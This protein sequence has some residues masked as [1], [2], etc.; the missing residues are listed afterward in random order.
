MENFLKHPALIVGI[1]AVITVFFGIQLPRVELDNNNIRFLP[2]KNQAKI[3]SDYIDNTFGGQVMILVGIE[4]PYRSVFEKGFLGRV[5]EFV[6]AV[7]GVEFVKTINSIMSTQYISGD[8]ESIIVSDL[9]P[10]DFSGTAEEIAELRRRIASW[11]LLQGALVSNDLSATQIVITLDVMTADSARPEVTRSLNAIKKLAGEIFTDEEELYFTG[12]PILSATVNESII[13]DNLLLIP[14]VVLVVLALLFFSFRRL[15]FVVLPIL[16]VLISVIWTIGLT[17]LLNL[18]LSIITTILPVILVAIGHAYGVHILT[19]YAK[20]TRSK[21]LT[22]EEHRDIVL[23]LMKKMLKPVTLAALTTI[24]GFV[25]FCFTPIVPMREFGYCASV[26]VITVYIMAILFIPSML[27]LRGPKSRQE[28]QEKQADDDKLSNTI[29]NIFLGISRRRVLV[30]FLAVLVVVVSIYA[31]SIIDVDNSV[32]EFF[33]RET[34]IS[35]SDRF[36]QEHFS[37]SKDLNLVFQTGTTEEL[38]HPDALLAID[39]LS[40]Y[41]TNHVP[42]AGKVAGFTDVIK[43]INQVFNVDQSPDGMQRVTQHIETDTFGFGEDIG[44]GDFGFGG[45]EDDIAFEAPVQKDSHDLNLYSIADIIS[46]FDSAAGISPAMS[47]TG[48]VRELKRLTN[49][50]GMAYY[51]IPADPARYGKETPEELQRLI[52]NYLVLL[53]GDEDSGYSDDPLEPTAIRMLIQLRTTGSKAIRDVIK[54]I[55]EYIAANFP[56]NVNVMIGGGAT[57]EI[58]ITD[59]ILS[60]QVIS[61]FISVFMILLIVGIAHK[62]LI[63][64]V[65][66]A[67]PLILAVLCNFIVMGFFGI[68]LNLGTA[69]IASITISI[70]IDDAIHFIEF[71]KREYRNGEEGSLRR[72]FIA[73]GKAICITA[74]TV[75][76]GFGVLAFSRFKIISELG[77]LIGLSMLSTTLVSLTVIPALFTV[78]KPRFI[79]KENQP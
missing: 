72:T 74:M 33:R 13:A 37:G 58:A 63:A 52:A 62:S 61:I 44:F 64:G 3:I 2:N 43:R 42:E 20:D 5:K 35:R 79:Y 78:I 29:A 50:D 66:G 18:K 49:Y 45:F 27:L 34:D 28:E 24:T 48:L 1:I 23:E 71:F 26:G 46:F 51:E 38:L 56:K 67:I 36:I 39:G 73:C 14:L 60:S 21:T 59:L 57:Q 9:I 4:R 77:I 47:G 6:K 15:I 11:D 19:H 54:T 40:A 10:A 31:L 68:K 32:V 25:S 12:Q 55:E 69:M 8:S 53:A 7:E 70:G 41:L 75:G 65:I 30:L 16:T 76:A 17:P 22:I